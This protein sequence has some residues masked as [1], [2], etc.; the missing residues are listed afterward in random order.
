[1]EDS[2]ELYA[3]YDQELN[4]D[5]ESP[6]QDWQQEEPDELPPGRSPT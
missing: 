4:C 3:D 6:E 2:V 1:M 5:G